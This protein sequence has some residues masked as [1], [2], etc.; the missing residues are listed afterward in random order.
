[1]SPEEALRR[2]EARYRALAEATSSI[3][4]LLPPSGEFESEVP[5]W[6][7]F[8]GQPFRAYRGQGWLE[9]IH[10]DDRPRVAAAW[11]RTVET[12]APYEEEYRLRDGG[13][14]ERTVISCAAPVRGAVGEVVE[15]VGTST[16]VTEQREAE[17]GLRASEHDLRRIL[18][19]IT[20]A[21]YTLDREWR[22]TFLNGTARQLLRWEGAD[23]LGRNIWEAL[24]QTGPWGVRVEFER[25]VRDRVPVRFT[26]SGAAEE[27]RYELRAFPYDD[28]LSVF[29]T[30]VTEQWEQEARLHLLRQAVEA[31]SNGILITD[32]ALADDP[33]TYV[34]PAFTAI[35]GYT[36]EEAVGRNCRFLQGDDHAQPALDRLRRALQEGRPSSVVLRNYRADGALFWNELHVAPVEAADGTLLNYVGVITDATARVEAER[37]QQEQAGQ[38]RVLSHQLVEAQEQERRA[39]ARELH[40]E[41]GQVLTALKLT[42]DTV[43]R[44]PVSTGP[45]LDD[46]QGIVHRLQEQ[47]R[48]LSL[49]L[50]PSMLDDLGLVPALLYLFERVER[51]MGLTV[52]FTYDVALPV[53][54][55]EVATAAYRIA[56]EAMTNVAR[57]AGGGEVDVDLRVEEERHVLELV[58]G[59]HDHGAGFDPAS[60]GP[61]SSGLSGM[62]ERAHLLGGTLEVVSGHGTGTRVHAHLPLKR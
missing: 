30:E 51:Q 22:F 14:R 6:G 18:A 5:A 10:P 38:L 29:F 39:L 32:S 45:L 3:V 25:A 40:D 4:W 61:A 58:L 44:D 57:H 56:Q 47:V 42:L 46:A 53:L 1:M 41:I 19:S 36:L 62:R 55:P 43:R 21:F 54:P 15:W 13:G 34:N 20:D 35:T 11:R 23:L 8:T 52:R 17:R 31:S 60:V 28:G 33:I 16:D 9:A 50:R 49:D 48:T 27:G 37:M 26:V 2:S 7:A 24:P 59:V 12:G